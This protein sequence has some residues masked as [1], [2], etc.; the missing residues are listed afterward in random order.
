MQLNENLLIEQR[1]NQYGSIFRKIDIYNARKRVLNENQYNDIRFTLTEQ[2]AIKEMFQIMAYKILE[3][4]LPGELNE[5]F[6]DSIKYGAQNIKD[7]VNAGV[8]KLQQLPEKAKKAYEF[9]QQIIQKSVTKVSEFI[10]YVT[11]LFAK[12]ADKVRDAV[13]MLGG[14]GNDT[15]VD[16]SE[17]NQQANEKDF[18]NAVFEYIQQNKDD[19]EL[20]EGWFQE[21]IGKNLQSMVSKNKFF[22]TIMGRCKNGGKLSIWQTIL[23]SLVAVITISIIGWVLS[24]LGVGVATV[25]A[26]KTILNAVW[27]LRN[28]L[29]VIINRRYQMDK[30]GETKFW[31]ASVIIQLFIVIGTPAFFQIPIVK[32]WMADVI[33]NCINKGVEYSQE[34]FSKL[35][36]LVGKNPSIEQVSDVIENGASDTI[37]DTVGNGAL[38]LNA[39]ELANASKE[40]AGTSRNRPW[41]DKLLELVSNEKIAVHGE[42]NIGLNINF[43]GGIEKFVNSDEFQ[44][45][46]QEHGLKMEDISQSWIESTNAAGQASKGVILSFNNT[47][48]N[49]NEEEFINEF[50]SFIKEHAIDGTGRAVDLG[51]ANIIQAPEPVLVAQ[52]DQEILNPGAYFGG[53]SVTPMFSGLK[54]NIKLSLGSEARKNQYVTVTNFKD[55]T[56]GEAQDALKVLGENANNLGFR[57]LKAQDNMSKGFTA[58]LSMISDSKLEEAEG[59]DNDNKLKDAIET[60][61]DPKNDKCLVFFTNVKSEG[62]IKE[63]PLVAINYR[64]LY[65][66]DLIKSKKLKARK[67][68]YFVKGLFNHL[69]IKPVKDGDVDTQNEIKKFL[70]SYLWKS[71]SGLAKLCQSTIGEVKHL[72]KKN[73]WIP[74]AE[75]ND[76]NRLELGNFTTAEFS[77]ILNNPKES[78]KYFGGG[79]ATDIT[80]TDEHGNVLKAK[81]RH[82]KIED[83]QNY[84]Q[85]KL[86]PIISNKATDVYK[87]LYDNE[88]I[89]KAF[90]NDKGEFK[91]VR[92]GDK[93][94]PV[95][96]HPTISVALFRSPDNFNTEQKKTIGEYI[97]QKLGKSEK[98]D[99]KDFARATQ[100][101][102]SITWKYAG[103]RE[104][105]AKQVK[106]AKNNTTNES[107][108]IN[109]KE[110]KM[111]SETVKLT[112]KYNTNLSESARKLG[113][114][115]DY[116]K[117][118]ED[119]INKNGLN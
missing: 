62:K 51:P 2:E 46:M 19:K 100:L 72:G 10:K 50:N 68:P 74:K 11:E 34:I 77:D 70:M 39:E 103:D 104:A 48:S 21:G 55:M 13:I 22:A 7:K 23:V 92:Q 52:V 9:C 8:E 26:I 41:L 117:L 54:G 90:F 47:A 69:T 112:P 59:Q 83:K 36:E 115:K 85:E 105:W 113:Y 16:S 86:Y 57:R 88:L 33:N 49:F 66:V 17:N 73:E 43:K 102:S 38:S 79:Y 119:W 114:N 29:K 58:K 80:K 76:K 97:M 31:N 12:L 101:L 53:L 37:S 1:A 118:T 84:V 28:A 81:N 111:Y 40:M 65:A 30:T 15:I 60:N 75:D 82:I 63:L 14:F 109:L 106:Q 64:T 87:E 71:V 25:A 32:E 107:I 98:A 99:G 3:N 89:R 42:H 116:I 35:A 91:K 78:Y 93:N 95:V 67:N 110:N 61:A 56:F 44:T 20:T 27:S 108:L 45:F 5:G 18:L 4:N 6:W 24:T 96:L 94:I